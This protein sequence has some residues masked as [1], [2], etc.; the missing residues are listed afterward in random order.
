MERVLAWRQ[1]GERPGGERRK[2]E[3]DGEWE[4]LILF[5]Q[6]G[7]SS[8]SWSQWVD[9]S[10]HTTSS[11]T[12]SQWLGTHWKAYKD[13]ASHTVEGFFKQHFRETI[14][15]HTKNWFGCYYDRFC[16]FSDLLVVL[17]EFASIFCTCWCPGYPG[18]WFWIDFEVLFNMFSEVLIATS[19]A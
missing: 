18:G 17:A 8:G 14:L 16:Y 4:S 19:V 3:V 2:T 9:V 11:P 13:D 12:L 10:T 1:R 7:P 5:M 15:K 6:K